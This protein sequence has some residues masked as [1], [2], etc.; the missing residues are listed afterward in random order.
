MLQSD[1][2]T[3]HQSGRHNTNAVL[4]KRRHYGERLGI[5][6]RLGQN[7]GAECRRQ[8][9][10]RAQRSKIGKIEIMLIQNLKP[11]QANGFFVWFMFVSTNFNA[12]LSNL[13]RFFRLYKFKNICLLFQWSDIYLPGFL[14]DV[15]LLQAKTRQVV[16]TSFFWPRSKT[17]LAIQPLRF[18]PFQVFPLHS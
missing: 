10:L 11:V 1:N 2:R 3:Q 13:K 5:K 8:R 14:R 9:H 6:R 7:C 12:F 18:R 16:P 4:C 17:C 15:S